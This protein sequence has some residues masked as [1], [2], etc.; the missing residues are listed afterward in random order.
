LSI[1]QQK[2]KTIKCAQELETT[3]SDWCVVGLVDFF[4]ADITMADTYL[5]LH[6]EGVCK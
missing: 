5:S 4:W 2:S 6:H 3:L 1:L